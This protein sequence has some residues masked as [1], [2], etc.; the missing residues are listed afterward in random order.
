MVNFLQKIKDF[1]KPSQKSIDG[2]HPLDGPVRA[3]NEKA[4]KP[5]QNQAP[6]QPVE[7]VKAEPEVINPTPVVQEIKKEQQPVEAKKEEVKHPSPK[8]KKPTPPPH[9]HTPPKNKTATKPRK[10]RAKK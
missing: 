2:P 6:A 8:V 7:P 4:F 1:F 5:F 9:I 10:P 3:G